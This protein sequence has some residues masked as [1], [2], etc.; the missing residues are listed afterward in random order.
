MKSAGKNNRSGQIVDIVGIH[1][2][3]RGRQYTLHPDGCGPHLVMR[4]ALLCHTTQHTTQQ[5]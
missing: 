4:D 1:E 3:N 5:K 2:S